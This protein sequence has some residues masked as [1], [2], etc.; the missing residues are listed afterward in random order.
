MLKGFRDFILR[1]NVV[2]LATAVIIGAAFT[3]IVTAISDQI[4]KP[5]IAAMGTPDAGGLGFLIR[6]NMPST[7]VNFG[8]VITAVINFII[9][10]AVVYFVI[11]LPMN[12]FNEWRTRHSEEED[13]PPTSEDLLTEI[14]D[15][16]I[17]QNKDAGVGMNNSAH[18]VV[19]HPIN[20]ADRGDAVK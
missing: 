9:I 2:E 6:P 4:I 16:L 18:S 19:D 10:A 11:V 5:L 14:R 13:V 15:L 1:G 20:P 7:F 17:A 12:K 8:A 3:A